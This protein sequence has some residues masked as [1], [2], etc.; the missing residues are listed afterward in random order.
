MAF[1]MFLNIHTRKSIFLLKKARKKRF[2]PVDLT[3]KRGFGRVWGGRFRMVAQ[4][5]C[6]NQ[7]LAI[8]L[9]FMSK[10][11]IF[12]PKI[13]RF[14]AK[15]RFFLCKIHKNLRFSPAKTG[16]CISS[17]SG[18]GQPRLSRWKPLSFVQN[19]QNRPPPRWLTGSK[20]AGI[21]GATPN[22]TQFPPAMVRLE[23][24]RRQ[25]GFGW[26]SG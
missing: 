19:H 16:W 3:R 21:M 4:I 25:H 18:V 24:Y 22:L 17:F 23:M 9:P 26:T 15:S 13:P 1:L 20:C 8:L 12:L 2:S 5:F 7:K 6:K 14:F 10:N 11:G